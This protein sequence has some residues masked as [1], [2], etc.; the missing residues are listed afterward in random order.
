MNAAPLQGREATF[1]APPVFYRIVHKTRFASGLWSQGHV[2][3]VSKVQ[4]GLRRR[5]P[6][7]VAK[8]LYQQVGSCT[9][10]AEN[11]HVADGVPTA[12]GR[13][14]FDRAPFPNIMADSTTQTP[15]VPEAFLRKW[16][17]RPFS[18]CD[19]GGA[20]VAHLFR[21]D[22]AGNPAVSIGVLLAGPK[23]RCTWR[24]D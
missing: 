1:V 15:S 3:E 23:R 18:C 22:I 21:K 10:F 5:L 14:C 8:L 16:A 2:F 12:L 11:M 19:R 4:V 17:R 13:Y 6:P 24:A 7:A 20:P 9:P